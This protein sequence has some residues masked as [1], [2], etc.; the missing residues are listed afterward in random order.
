[1]PSN[2]TQYP[3]PLVAI[4]EALKQ[5]GQGGYDRDHFARVTLDHVTSLFDPLDGNE[6]YDTCHA[7][8]DELGLN[9]YRTQG[10]PGENWLYHAEPQDA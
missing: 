5:P 7:I 9:L 2:N 10:K 4:R 3:T 6:F 8:A 1:M